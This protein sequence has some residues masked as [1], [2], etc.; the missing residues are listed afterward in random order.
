MVRER[1]FEISSNSR[2][3]GP[4]ERDTFD[5]KSRHSTNGELARFG[6]RM[7]L[8][9]AI[10]LRRK[11]AR[12]RDAPGWFARAVSLAAAFHRV[13]HQLP[14]H[15]TVAGFFSYRRQC[16]DSS[17]PSTIRRISRICITKFLGYI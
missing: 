3:S 13:F 17:R 11:E 9:I 4:E 5:D 12:M 7:D 16:S 14:P 6:A 8:W 2:L 15:L 10:A 1:E